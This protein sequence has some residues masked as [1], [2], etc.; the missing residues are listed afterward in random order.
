MLSLIPGEVLDKLIGVL[1]D[2]LGRVRIGADVQAQ[3]GI[4]NRQIGESV[5]ARDLKVMWDFLPG[6]PFAFTR[7]QLDVYP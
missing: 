6:I 5:E 7:F 4:T 2:G 3:I 1:N